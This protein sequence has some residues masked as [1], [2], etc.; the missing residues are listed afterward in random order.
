MPNVVMQNLTKMMHVRPWCILTAFQHVTGPES[1]VIKSFWQYI[2]GVGYCLEVNK[3]EITF[4]IG[5]K[6]LYNVWESD[7]PVYK[8]FFV[9]DRQRFANIPSKQLAVPLILQ[10]DIASKRTYLNTVLTVSTYFGIRPCMRK[11]L[12]LVRRI[13]ACFIISMEDP[14]EASQCFAKSKI[15]FRTL[16]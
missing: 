1:E 2:I 16:S 6:N 8:A 15:T 14:L 10:L 5:L 9:E 11:E 13:V 12:P 3:H 4:S 7:I